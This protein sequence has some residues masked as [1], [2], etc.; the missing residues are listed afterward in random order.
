MIAS[1]VNELGVD[2]Q[3]VARAPNASF[4]DISDAHFAGRLRD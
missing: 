2:S 3:T 1:A 4:R